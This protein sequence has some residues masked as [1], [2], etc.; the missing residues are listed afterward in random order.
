MNT[1]G[2][3]RLTAST[4][5]C[6]VANPVAN[7]AAIRGVLDQVADSDI[8]LFPE[9]CVTGYTCADLFGQQRLLDAAVEQTMQLAAAT[10]GRQQL[11]VVGLPVAVE[12]GL[13]N[14]A[15]MLCDGQVLG[16][17]PKQYIPNYKEF[18][19]SRW[20]AAARGYERATIEFGGRETPF[21]VDLL[22]D[23]GPVV[24]GVEICE[25]LWVPTPPSSFQALAGANLLLNL[26]ASNET[27]G[28]NKYRGGL[29]V[30]QSGRCIAAYAYASSGPTESTTDLVF[31]G[32]CL[33][34][35]NGALLAESP[36][37]G[38]G[39]PVRRDSYW[40]TADVDVEHLQNDRRT[41]ISFD[42]C[43]PAVPRTYRRIAFSLRPKMEGL[44]RTVV[45]RPFVPGEDA[46]L[47]RRCAEIFGVQ[48]A[49]LAKRIEQLPA[50]VP[51]NIGI[52]G[53]LDSTLSLLVAVKMCD[54]IGQPHSRIHGLTMPGFGTTERTRTNALAL[55]EHLGVSRDLIDIRPLCL[56][57][58]RAI[59]YR[60][61]DIDPTGASVDEFQRTLSRIP[62]EKCHD[63]VFENVQARI[64]TLLLMS[65]GFVIGTG[66]LSELALGWSTY[67]ADQ[68]SMYNPNCS[69]PKTLVRFLVRHVAEREFD[70]PARQTLLS[71]VAGVI[72]PELL[73]LGADGQSLQSTEESLGRFELHDFFLYHFVR[74]GFSPEKILFLSRFAAFEDGVTPAEIE[75]T[76]R[77][78]YRRFFANQFKRTCVPDGPKVGTVSLS[79]R[80]DW[81]M[82]SDADPS[83]WLEKSGG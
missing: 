11:V 6:S 35:E 42:E 74:N 78:F 83:L 66:D 71:I 4:L 5:C 16:I 29:V 23:A 40:I 32:H 56:D 1:F 73:P 46:E 17:V 33:I 45:A 25:D 76:L 52:S 60:P 51:L 48:C 80:G 18:Y 58:F 64:R 53:G 62:P 10:R 61:F 8:V 57:T 26:S 36:R 55:M 30:G 34:A 31:G 81:R 37:V 2:F 54:M 47:E 77:T 50:D 22:F 41:A 20:F 19:E 15:A 49:A 12:N 7:M 24:V 27:I 65:R 43:V 44:R 82:P 39:S 79:P 13:Y 14:S 38:D 3:V 75:K 69:I 63:L 68:M 59:A 21:G 72:S 28:K 67:N 9:L 70:G